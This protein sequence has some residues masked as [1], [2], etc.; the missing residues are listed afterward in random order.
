MSGSVALGAEVTSLEEER[1]HLLD[2]YILWEDSALSASQQVL[3]IETV[4]HYLEIEFSFHLF[5]RT[6]SHRDPSPFLEISPF[7]REM[8]RRA[9]VKIGRDDNPQM[10]MP[11]KITDW[12]CDTVERL[13]LNDAN[14]D[15][16]T[17]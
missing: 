9:G 5:I 10:S 2:K 14:F 16:G 8:R 13:R 11:R 3:W 15:K 1:Y 17:G 7:V 12:P 6:G 4:Y